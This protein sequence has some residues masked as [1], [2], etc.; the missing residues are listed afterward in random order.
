MRTKDKLPPEKTAVIRE[1]ITKLRRC[2]RQA[3]CRGH[4]TGTEALEKLMHEI[5]AS[6]LSS[7]RHTSAGGDAPGAAPKGTPGAAGGGKEI[8]R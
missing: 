8:T 7:S 5:R 2:D 1:Q 3:G 6:G 4:Q